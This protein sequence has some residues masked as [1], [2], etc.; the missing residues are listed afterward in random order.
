MKK[1]VLPAFLSLVLF[2]CST[3]ET[4]KSL[5][6]AEDL[7]SKIDKFESSRQNLA[8]NLSNATDKIDKQAEKENPNVSDVAKD[9]E[10]QINQ[11]RQ[12]FDGLEASFSEVGKSSEEYFKRLDEVTQVIQDPKIKASEQKKNQAIKDKYTGAYSDAV[13]Q[14]NK[15]REV[16]KEGGDYQQVLIASSMRQKIDKNITELKQISDKAK[17]ILAQLQNFS[18]EG[19]KMITS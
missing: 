17:A 16:L 15:V 18:I 4:Q 7:K 14:I 12:D 6:Y 3:S 9:W 11:T 10:A 1:L 2:A 8:D 13:D 19:K 5:N